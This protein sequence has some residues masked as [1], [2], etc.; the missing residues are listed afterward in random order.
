M[1]TRKF[2]VPQVCCLLEMSVTHVC[3]CVYIHAGLYA[4]DVCDTCVCVY[5]HAGLY[6][7]DVCVLKLV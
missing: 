5:S 4:R 6:A 1:T 2:I 7:R 3:V